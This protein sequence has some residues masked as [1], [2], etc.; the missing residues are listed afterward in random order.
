MKAL[1]VLVLM[2]AA[3]SGCADLRFNAS[4]LA[5]STA[6]TLCDWNQ[7]RHAA[8]RQ[9]HVGE[10]PQWENNPILGRSP[11]VSAVNVYFTSSLIVNAVAWYL[12]P[13]RWKSVI[14]GFLIGAESAT[15]IGNMRSRDDAQIV[16]AIMRRDGSSREAATATA[17]GLHTTCGM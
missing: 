7:T 13:A 8:A 5:V 12:M 6:V 15:V 16:Q 11:T 1:A 10:L 2:V 14:P 4:T 9:W 17:N 3:S